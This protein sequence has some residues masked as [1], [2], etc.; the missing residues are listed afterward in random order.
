MYQAGPGHSKARGT[1]AQ[2]LNPTAQARW[3]SLSLGPDTK[4]ALCCGGAE[5]PGAL[6]HSYNYVRSTD[7]ME[8]PQV[9][10]TN[11]RLVFYRVT[12]SRAQPTFGFTCSSL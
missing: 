8:A 6:L 9:R 10:F 2:G 7:V 1:Q 11:S 3:G 12:N 4:I 5:A